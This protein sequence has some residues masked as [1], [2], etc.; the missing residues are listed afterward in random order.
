VDQLAVNRVTYRLRVTPP[1]AGARPPRAM[2][3][4][5]RM[6]LTADG[7]VTTLLEATGRLAAAARA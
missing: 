3:P 4:I 1:V 2:D 5:D 6:P 7:T